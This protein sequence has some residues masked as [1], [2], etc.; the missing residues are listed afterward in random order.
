MDILQASGNEVFG[1]SLTAYMDADYSAIVEAFGKPNAEASLD[2]KVRFEWDL[3]VIGIVFT[4]YDWKSNTPAEFERDW[5]IGS[6]GNW[7]S[8]DKAKDLEILK[9]ALEEAICGA[10]V[11]PA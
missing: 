2:G 5:H 8:A 11:S 6:R 9:V 10:I 1:T 3:K 4:I 7:E